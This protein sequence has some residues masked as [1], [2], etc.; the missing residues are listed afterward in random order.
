MMSRL[1]IAAAAS[2]LLCAVSVGARA[3]DMAC[4]I[5]GSGSA[6][7]FCIDG[8]GIATLDGKEKAPFT[9]IRHVAVCG[10]RLVVANTSDVAFREGA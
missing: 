2:A 1:A 8:S 7:P 9:F 5:P 6:A 10:A 4:V 3:N